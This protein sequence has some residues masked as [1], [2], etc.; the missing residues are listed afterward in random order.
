VT[1]ENVRYRLVPPGPLS[2]NAVMLLA[3]AWLQFAPLGTRA[4]SGPTPLNYLQADQKSGILHVDG[5]HYASAK[6]ALSACPESGCVIDLRGNTGTEALTLGNIDPGGKPV[7]ILLGPYTYNVNTITLRSD[8][9]I[10]GAGGA[11]VLQSM[12]ATNSAVFVLPQQ[13][14]AAA[15]SVLLRDFRMLAAPGNTTQDA[16]DLDCS[17]TTGDGLFYSMI[18]GIT[19]E[20]F[21]GVSIRLRGPSNGF[22]SN[23]QF[24]TFQNVFVFRGTSPHSGEALRIEGANSNLTFTECQF[25]DN[26]GQQVGTNIYLGVLPGGRDGYPLSIHFHGIISQNA[27][28]AVVIN[29]GV[30][31]DFHDSH[32]ESIRT[33]GYLVTNGTFNLGILIDRTYFASDSYINSGKGFLVN[34][35]SGSGLNDIVFTNNVFGQFGKPPDHV[36]VGEAHWTACGNF[37]PSVAFQPCQ[38]SG[39]SIQAQSFQANQGPTQTEANIVAGP[40]WGIGATVTDVKGW[41]QTEQ[42]TINSGASSFSAEPTLSVTFP[43]AFSQ[44]P[45]CDLLVQDVKGSGG[46]ILF[47]P[48][49]ITKQ[50]ATFAAETYGGEPFVPAAN[51][52]YKVLLR[53]GP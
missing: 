2:L 52:S 10:I 38:Y 28:I 40:G 43:T 17:K 34:S 13:D 24:S 15:S 9:H 21:N 8:L 23:N 45:L 44:A 37:G 29:G 49:S 18:Q 7:T 27:D 33:G 50:S 42:F 32:H 36:L 12:S 16:F 30:N 20:Y 25:D 31:I 35:A 14:N 47:N 39:Q 11:T 26:A 19:I 46:A 6:D 48:E 4:T 22:P 41:T 3:W 5:S 1:R 53:C 51:E